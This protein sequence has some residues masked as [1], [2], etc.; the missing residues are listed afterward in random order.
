MRGNELTWRERPW[1]L[2]LQRFLDNRLAPLGLLI[3]LVLIFLA[4]SAP[5]L[6]SY[7]PYQV[8]LHQQFLKPSRQ[9][10]LGTDEYGRDVLTRLIYG[11]RISLVIGLVPACLSTLVGTLLGLTAG[12][13]GGR[14]DAAIMRLADLVMAFPSLLLAMVVMYTLGASLLNLFIA[15]AAVNWAGCARVVRAQTLSL[16]ERDYVRAAKAIGV[17]APTILLRHIL[18]NCL[19]QILILLSLSIPSAIMSEAS[20]SFLGLGA[21]PP[22]ASWG[23]MISAGRRYMMQAPWVTL[24]PGLA[25]LVT[26]LGFNFLGDGL[27][28]A[29]GE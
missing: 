9:H 25:I 7:D 10:L 1:L 19:P 16:R 26:V 18:P 3:V 5:L 28:D 4:L 8:D 14:I 12:Y 27:R 13:Y 2:G 23:L 17:S 15:L 24:L 20:L 22:E 21:Q 29:F 11:T 6:C